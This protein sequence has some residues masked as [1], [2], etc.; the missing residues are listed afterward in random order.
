MRHLNIQ[1]KIANFAT[2]APQQGLAKNERD[3]FYEDLISLVFKVSESKFF[4]IGGD[5]N[6]HLGEDAS[7]YDGI[8]GGVGMVSEA[9][10]GGRILEMGSSLDMTVCN[11]FFKKRDS[12]LITYT[13]GPFQDSY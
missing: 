8:H 10:R 7:G 2:C 12:Q 1:R 13:S 3:K 4:M 6:G 5:L 9:K 11:L